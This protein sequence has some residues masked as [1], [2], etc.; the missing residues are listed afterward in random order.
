MSN[1]SG[2]TT[3]EFLKWLLPDEGHKVLC[4][5]RDPAKP[6]RQV[7]FQD[8]EAMAAAALEA[9]AQGLEVYHACATYRTGESRRGANVLGVSAFWLDVDCGPSKPYPDAAAGYRAVVEFVGRLGVPLPLVVASGRGLHCYWGPDRVLDAATWTAAAQQLQAATERLGLAVDPNRT[10]DAAS[11]LRPPGTRNRKYDAVLPVLCE[12]LP[13]FVDAEAFIRCLTPRT[14]ISLNQAATGGIKAP[15]EAPSMTQGAAE[16]S[17]TDGLVKRAGWCLGVW[18]MSVEAAIAACQGWNAYNVPPLD[19]EVVEQTVININRL[20]EEKSQRVSKLPDEPVRDAPWPF[21]FSA[22]KQLMTHVDGETLVVYKAPVYVTGYRRAEATNET[23]TIALRH[24]HPHE[25]WCDSVIEWDDLT[26][27]TVCSRLTARGMNIYP[28]QARHVVQYVQ[29]CI[30]VMQNSRITDLEY[31]QLGWKGANFLLGPE[32]ISEGQ[33]TLVGIGVEA[34]QRAEMLKPKGT[35]AGWATEASKLFAKGLEG[36]AFM[37]LASFAAP[38]M[39]FRLEAGGT[40]VS[41]VS[42]RSG[43][44]KT[45]GL[46]A[47]WSIWGDKYALDINRADTINSRFRSIALLAN[48]PIVFDEMRNRDPE[49]VKDFILT[50]TDG[51]DKNRLN[52]DGTLRRLTSGWSTVLISASNVSLAETVAY[53][54][55]GAQAARVLEYTAELPPD[56][57]AA[58]GVKMRQHFA[59]NSGNAGRMFM[60]QLVRGDVLEWAAQAAEQY[61]REFARAIGS[62]TETRFYSALLACTKVAAKLL[63]KWGMLEFDHDRILDFGVAAAQGMR[64]QIAGTHQGP[65]D[66]LANFVN[67]HWHTCLSVQQAVRLSDV[68][69]VRQHPRSGYLYMRHEEKEGHL[70]I[71]RTYLKKWCVENKVVMHEFQRGL[72]KLGVLKLYDTRRALGAGTPYAAGG[73]TVCWLIDSAHPAC[74]GLPRAVEKVA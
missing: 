33:S 23:R 73:A 63:R 22:H 57:D 29:R 4:L 48:L 17:R 47:A 55:E 50:F 12:D 37:L 74:S 1:G 25:G 45:T 51:R 11:I 16:G 72:D 32:L 8:V 40:I 44:G 71:D 62:Q 54:N 60:H 43:T 15:A 24:W 36:Q 10:A 56:L 5:F 53:D 64:L 66:I 7:F 30:D 35:Y 58:D 13:D 20:E 19:A 41:A 67:Q 59:A 38:L 2:P 21:F 39:R 6:P 31:E 46:T 70:L 27:K 42:Q 14:P 65:T 49:V 61:D 3:G 69:I 9:D 26:A 28:A 68:A 52:Q 34:R 18:H